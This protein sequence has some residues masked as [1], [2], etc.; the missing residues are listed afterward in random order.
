MKNNKLKISFVIP[1][2]N[3]EKHLG[4]VI[5]SIHNNMPD[6]AEYEIIVVDNGSTDHTVD[7]AKGKGAK[8]F[9]GPNLTISALR[10]IGVSKIKYENI[11]FLDADV[12]LSDFWGKHIKNVIDQ[13]EKEKP[14]IT[15][16]I[17]GLGHN[18]MW[19]EKNWYGVV[20]SRKKINYINS[21]HLILKKSIFNKIGG[22]N[23]K[24][25]SAEDYEF[26]LRGK[27]IGI[28][29]I[30]NPKL[31]VHHD[32]YPKTLRAFFYRERWHG[33]GDYLSLKNFIS[34]KAAI[35]SL[36]LFINLWISIAGVL[37]TQKISF[38]IIY[39]LVIGFL[40]GTSAYY[41]CQKINLS[42]AI[43]TF[44]YGIYF[45]ARMLSFLDVI[46]KRHKVFAN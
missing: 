7:I 43:C 45:F 18:P 38:L 9:D 11:V 15:G 44:L 31:R 37:Y 32:G 4:G 1:T 36:F 13:L 19:L 3:E 21:G 30:N 23:E 12:Y 35:I 10:N 46:S 40:C 16:S 27:K 24:L 29:I 2:F 14:A 17:C 22:F 20:L 33:R 6:K 26:C 8:V 42:F 41:R 39:L 28:K 25:E 34:S 5:D